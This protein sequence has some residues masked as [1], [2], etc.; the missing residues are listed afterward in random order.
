M[1]RLLVT[2]SVAALVAAC[3]G[4]K[5][6]EQASSQTT[7]AGKSITIKGSDTMVHLVA[8]WA[9]DYHKQHLDTD[10]SVTGG[11]SGTGISA[12]IAGG[13]DIC[14]ASREITAQETEKAK[15]K[16]I[17]PS[18]TVVARDGIAVIVHPSNP[19]NELTM[20]QLAKLYT[21][22]TADWKEVGGNAGGVVLLSRESSSGT[23]AFFQEHVLKKQDY[24]PRARLMP[25][26]S[27]IIQAVSEDVTAIGYVGLGYV[28]EAGQTVKTLKIKA[29]ADA[30]SVTPSET[31]VRDGSYSIA[32]PL[33]FYL[34]GSVSK[35]VQDFVKYC[36]SE[37]GQKVV[38]E[39][40]FVTVQ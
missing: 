20:E 28:Q 26:T 29:N 9:E 14:S 15:Q 38:R 13:T 35:E 7:A 34:G 12:L 23:Y 1:K 6:P 31:T 2:I 18:Q 36:V 3:G 24:S 33:Y 16:G 19:I 4:S 21:G 30:P 22:A 25:A 10:V 5:A 32:R 40:G 8:A 37:A 17:I 11:G 27:S 39:K